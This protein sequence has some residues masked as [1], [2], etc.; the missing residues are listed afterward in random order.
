MAQREKAADQLSEFA[1]AKSVSHIY[2]T[3]VLVSKS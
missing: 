2:I 1:K 3:L